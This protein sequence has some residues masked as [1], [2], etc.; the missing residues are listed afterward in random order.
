[1]NSVPPPHPK[2]PPVL[3]D[4]YGA[5]S[6]PG[7]APAASQHSLFRQLHVIALSALIANALALLAK[8]VL[9]VAASVFL[10]GSFNPWLLLMVINQSRL[11]MLLM[12][13]LSI[14]VIALDLIMV[15]RAPGRVRRGALVSLILTAVNLLLLVPAMVGLD[16]VMMLTVVVGLSFPPLLL[17]LPYASALVTIGLMMISILGNVEAFIE[18]R[19]STGQGALIR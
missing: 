9:A 11:P 18:T 7:L 12:V 16:P 13:L 15:A 2:P 6:T 5:Y 3:E 8:V 4:P 14:G 10:D 1:M 19:R 17:V